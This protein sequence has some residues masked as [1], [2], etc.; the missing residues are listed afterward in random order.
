MTAVLQ[1]YLEK[2]CHIYLDNILIWSENI[3]EHTKHIDMVMAA[4]H[5]ARLYCNPDKCNFYLQE[6]DFLGHHISVRGIEPQTS[7][8]DRITNWLIPKSA[9]DVRAFLGLVQ[10]I[11]AFL[12]QL[13]DHTSILIPLTNK[14]CCRN[15]PTW[16][17]DHQMAFDVI[18]G[19]VL[20]TDC[21]T[22]IDHENPCDNKIFITCDASD[23]CTGITLS[24][25]PT[26]ESAHLVAFD[27]MQLKGAE[28][29]YPVHEKELLAIIHTLKKWYSD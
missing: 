28:K 20:N 13:A 14:E 11:S 10:Y 16:N 25:G 1:E 21:L 2:I 15:F 29:N 3:A 23:W 5:R 8:I 26:W 6:L 22:T 18:N 9:T 27:F 17:S 19:L 12:P 24:F 4:L 7:K